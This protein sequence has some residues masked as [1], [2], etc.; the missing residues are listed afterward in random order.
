MNINPRAYAPL[1]RATLTNFTPLLT[2]CRRRLRNSL[3]QSSPLRQN[4]SSQFIGLVD[5]NTRNNKL[6]TIESEEYKTSYREE[7]HLNLSA[8]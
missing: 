2:T 1:K 6:T 5:K 3:L 8:Y 7:Q 4:Y